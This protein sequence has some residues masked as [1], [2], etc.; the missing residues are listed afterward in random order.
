MKNLFFLLI[1]LVTLFLLSNFYLNDFFNLEELKKNQ[2]FIKVWIDK[3]PKYSR[4]LFFISYI[5]FAGL[6]LPL[7][8]SIMTI[9]AGA[10]FGLLE[11]I[12]IVSFASTLGACLCFLISRHFLYD[13]FNK[14]FSKR[15]S[16]IYQN[17]K[18]DGAWY[19]LSLRL[20]PT[21]SYI[22]INLIMGVLPISI[23]KFYY[24][25]QI[26][27]FPATIV[28]V[29]AGSEISKINNINDIMSLPLL[30]SFILIAILPLLIKWVIKKYR[31]PNTF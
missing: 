31:M 10:L 21:V 22:F 8:P 25:S 16:F 29:N 28:Y 27:M 12:I 11:G 19:L 20:I 18:E 23:K 5:I 26:G 13:Y 9:A 24:I 3:N 14:K 1:F 30:M 17:F 4:S 7:L 6:S 15:F 2:V